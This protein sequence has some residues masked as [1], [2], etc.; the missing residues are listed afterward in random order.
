ML[1]IA[2]FVPCLLDLIK[3]CH[4]ERGT[5]RNFVHHANF[6]PGIRT[7]FLFA[8]LTLPHRALIRN[9]MMV[10]GIG[11]CF[12]SRNYAREIHLIPLNPNHPSALLL[13]LQS[14]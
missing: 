4:F 10:S 14:T 9:D 8:A 12:V 6:P 1:I 5:R 13:L 11:D 2:F 3:P 7:R